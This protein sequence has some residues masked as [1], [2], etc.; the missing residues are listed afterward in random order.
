MAATIDRPS[1]EPPSSAAA[2]RA[3]GIE[4]DEPFE[5][6]FGV[7]GGDA[8]A[9]VGD[10]DHRAWRRRHLPHLCQAGRPGAGAAAESDG[11][12]GARWGVPQR[13]GHQVGDH[14]AQPWLVADNGDGFQKVFGAPGQRFQGDEAILLTQVG[15]A[16]DIGADA[17]QVHLA[18][19]GGAL[20]IDRCQEHEVVEQQSHPLRLGFDAADGPGGAPPRW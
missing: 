11:D 8:R 9:G 19:L 10:R 13:V 15:V 6:R 7:L 12:L 20:L 2:V 16:D 4:A 5:D 1:P 14:L 17:E 3:A 18:F